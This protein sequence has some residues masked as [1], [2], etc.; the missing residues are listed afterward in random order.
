M[1]L[2]SSARTR[3]AAAL[4]G[5]ALAGCGSWASQGRDQPA[6]PMHRG[7]STGA[8]WSGSTGATSSGGPEPGPGSAAAAG[9]PGQ[10]GPGMGIGMMRDRQ[11]MCDVVNN[12]TS[13]RTPEQRDALM[14]QYLAGMTPEMRERHL[15]M[16]QQQCSQ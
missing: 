2:N 6:T 7:P 3:A 12:I 14:S 15:R 5:A 1:R 11:A 8:G 9:T 13:A 4:L 16:M 10:M